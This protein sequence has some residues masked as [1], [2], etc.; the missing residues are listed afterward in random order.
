MAQQIADAGLFYADVELV[1]NGVGDA[2]NI[3]AGEQLR[4]TGYKSDGYR[5]ATKDA[6]LSFSV[7]EEPI[8]LISNTILEPGVDDDPQNATQV[9][10][11]NIAV[12]YE[13][14]STVG[15]VHNFITSDTERVVCSSPLGRHLIPHYVRYDFSYYGGSSEAVVRDDHLK[16]INGLAPTSVL[17]SSSLQAIARDRGA[18]RVVNPITML[19]VVHNVDRSVWVQRSQDSLSTGRLSAFIP[20]EI[21]ISRKTIGG[22]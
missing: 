21:T 10:G 18:S 1:S 8:L 12:V 6:N 5:V 11:Q 9:T 19:A 2:W 3:Q 20:D 17:S 13:R 16:Y 4:V 14:S 15:A 7:A 22:L